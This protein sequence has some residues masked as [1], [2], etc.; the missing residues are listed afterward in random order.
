MEM[1]KMSDDYFGP[2]AVYD[3][4]MKITTLSHPSGD[5]DTVRKYVKEFADDK[6]ITIIFYVSGA[7]KPGERVIVL[8]RPGSGNYSNS[9]YVTLQAHM[10]MVC[11]PKNDIFPLNVFDYDINGEKWI[12][13]GDRASTSDPDKGTTL[14]A[15]D[16]IGVATALA[17]LEEEKLKEYPIECLFTVEE[18]T[19]MGG[20]KGFDKRLIEGRTYINL[21]AEDA[22]IIIYGSAGGCDVNY[23]GTVEL[24]DNWD[25]FV[26]RKVSISG[27]L[28][29]HSGIKINSGRLNAIKALTE[30]L[31]KLNRRITNLDVAEEEKTT[32]DLRLVSMKRDEETKM[33]SIPSSASAI[34]VIP[35]DKEDGFKRDFEAYCS[36]L[37]ELYQPEESNF[38]FCYQVCKPEEKSEKPLSETSTDVLLCL[39]QQIPHGVIRMIPE[40]VKLVETSTNLAG[41]DIVEDKVVIKASNRSSNDAS[42]VALKNIQRSVGDCFNY[43]VTHGEGYPSW[44][45]NESSNLLAKANDVYESIYH[46]DCAA[47]VIHAGLECSYI[48][49]KYGKEIDCISIGPTIVDPHSG[50]ERLKASTVETFYDAVTALIIKIYD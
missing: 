5:E 33:N 10:D 35:K 42:L 27:L 36:A 37:R 29:G 32:Y 26:T 3:H 24:S 17:I 31:I 25:N 6:H 48:V 44:Q 39:L 49:Q 1:Y 12:K 38:K 4:F 14:G 13:A 28:G 41:I 11:Y 20:A 45:P 2:K 8:R 9:P 23:E 34:I 16:G 46:E 19:T 22:P 43:S 15:D 21:D 50:G 7:K 40:N 30:I 47:T 18:E